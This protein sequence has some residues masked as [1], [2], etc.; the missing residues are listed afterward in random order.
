MGRKAGPDRTKIAKL[1]ACLKAYP[2]GL[3]TR[4]I[5]RRTGISKSSVQRYLTEFM[6]NEVEEALSVSGLVKLYRPRRR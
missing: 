2:D 4:E 5:A 1:R 6:T 3:W